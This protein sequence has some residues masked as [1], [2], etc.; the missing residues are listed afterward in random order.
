MPTELY[1]AIKDMRKD[2]IL[3]L[4][5]RTC[6]HNHSLL[7]HMN[8]YK[9][10]MFTEEKIG[11]F[12]IETC[13]L[14]ADYSYVF[15]YCIKDLAG[16]VDKRVIT[17]KEILS[18]TKDKALM[19]DM[20]TDFKKYDRLVTYYGARFDMPFVRT[21]ALKWNV[22]FPSYKELLHTDVYFII[23]HKFKLRRSSLQVACEMF[24]IGAKHHP[25]LPNIWQDAMAGDPKALDYVLTHN[26]E[27]VMSLEELYKKV[28]NFS[29]IKQSSI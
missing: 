26:E 25:I 9:K 20:V 1:N 12:D 28:K 17:R 22:E 7:E 14:K 2:E 23:K 10:G 3:K 13:G 5:S 18:K 21:R 11:F 27:D 15:S 6:K 4:A 24:D 19:E 8:C 29:P 16:G